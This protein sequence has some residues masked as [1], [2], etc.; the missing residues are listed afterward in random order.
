MMN[1]I[2]STLICFL[3][4]TRLADIYATKQTWTGA[5]SDNFS[6]LANWD[7]GL[8]LE[9]VDSLIIPKMTNGNPNPVCREYLIMKTILI[10]PG[11]HLH[12]DAVCHV[13]KYLILENDDKDFAHYNITNFGGLFYLLLVVKFI[14]QPGKWRF[15]SWPFFSHCGNAFVQENNK[16]RPAKWGLMHQPTSQD[17]FYIVR[18]NG[19]KRYL[20]ARSNT[21]TG[22]NW[23]EVAYDSIQISTTSTV[24]QRPIKQGEGYLI[25]PAKDQ[26]IGVF[27]VFYNTYLMGEVV[28]YNISSNHSYTN[29]ISPGA[30]AN[31]VH[32][33]WNF[34]APAYLGEYYSD[35]IYEE[36]G[37]PVNIYMYNAENGT[38]DVFSNLE[39]RK[40]PILIPFF[41]Q[42][43][44]P[45]LKMSYTAT[46]HRLEAQS[47]S[48]VFETETEDFSGETS[49]SKQV[50]G[51]AL[52][53][54]LRYGSFTDR[55]VVGFRRDATAEYRINEDAVKMMSPHT[56]IPQ[57]WSMQNKNQL[58]INILPDYQLPVMLGLHT[59]CA[60]EYRISLKN[61][62]R[63]DYRDEVWLT[64]TYTG[65]TINLMNEDY[66]FNEQSS[67]ESDSRFQL[68]YRSA[69][70]TGSSS[71]QVSCPF[72]VEAGKGYLVIRKP[73]TSASCDVYTICNYSYTA[74][75]DVYSASGIMTHRFSFPGNTTSSYSE[76]LTLP[77]GIYLLRWGP[78]QD[79]CKKITVF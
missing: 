59:G 70:S 77:P 42:A 47:A 30:S 6:T 67:L 65:K 12:I 25:T 64:D 26:T 63:L 23:E 50:S 2:K 72:I 14:I 13:K 28:Q 34:K 17:D 40:L 20:T 33:S 57:I 7:G 62:S 18:Y 60:G 69:L 3:L 48:V 5:V 22:Q 36:A 68:R 55:T 19:H 79:H 75:C 8:D 24:Y 54:L 27:F 52:E 32:A 73:D 11:G 51:V 53:I 10:K 1:V 71:A 78:Y 61:S 44:K 29:Y 43:T 49:R 15:V 66:V 16:T 46:R 31:D 38:Y 56:N 39:A 35:S 4:L 37:K 41:Y 58:A 9:T 76:K 45:L 21:L 74:G